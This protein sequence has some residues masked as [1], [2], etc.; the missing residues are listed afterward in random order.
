MGV[1]ET[2]QDGCYGGGESMKKEERKNRKIYDSVEGKKGSSGIGDMMMGASNGSRL[3]E[4]TG[5]FILLY[6]RQ[7]PMKHDTSHTSHTNAHKT[8]HQHTLLHTHSTTQTHTQMQMPWKMH[9]DSQVHPQADKL[10]NTHTH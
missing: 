8:H 3:M 2:E 5:G 1:I 10:L 7:G 9:G 4:A 6:H